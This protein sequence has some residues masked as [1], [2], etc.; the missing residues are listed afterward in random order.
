MSAILLLLR[1]PAVLTGLAFAAVL[2]WG[3]VQTLRLDYAKAET[4]A[5]RADYAKRDAEAQ[6]AADRALQVATERVRL[7]E[8]RSAQA[9][10][11]VSAQYQRERAIDAKRTQKVIADLHTGNLSLRVALATRA[12][13]AAGN[14]ADPAGAGTLGRDGSAGSGF[15]AEPD[16]AFLVS[17]A[18]RADE[19][20]KQLAAAQTIIRADREVCK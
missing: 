19:V 7:A 1:N 5:L 9:V 12:E 3:G 14:A 10:A 4:A 13:P 18:G 11:D 2:A 20:V 15:L 6:A 16:A 8:Q 17:E